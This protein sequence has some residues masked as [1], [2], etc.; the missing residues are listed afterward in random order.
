MWERIP[1]GRPER[2]ALGAWQHQDEGSLATVGFLWKNAGTIWGN[3]NR[4]YL[5]YVNALDCLTHNHVEWRPY[6]REEVINM[7]LSPMCNAGSDLW[8]NVCPLICF[9]VVEYHLPHRVKRQFGILQDFP[10]QPIDTGKD[11]HK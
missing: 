3:T 2:H 9:Y 10:P 4:R 5:D 8:R 7:N 11:L 1:V 6:D